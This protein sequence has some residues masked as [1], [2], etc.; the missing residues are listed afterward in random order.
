VKQANPLLII[1]FSGL[2]ALGLLTTVGFIHK[3]RKEQQDTNTIAQGIAYG[4][5]DS[6]NLAGGNFNT[7]TTERRETEILGE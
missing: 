6:E 3:M 2:I 5:L 1:V 4:N 7:T